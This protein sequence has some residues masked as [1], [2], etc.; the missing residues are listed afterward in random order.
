[1]Q[2]KSKQLLQTRGKL[3]INDLSFISLET[4][5]HRGVVLLLL[6]ISSLSF[7]FRLLVFEVLALLS[8]L[9]ALIFIFTSFALE[10]VFHF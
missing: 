2:L 1:M 7:L 6:L 5:Q 8:S 3:L 4:H 10:L 9:S